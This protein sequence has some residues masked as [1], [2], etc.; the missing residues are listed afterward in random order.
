[1]QR[2]QCEYIVQLTRGEQL[3]GVVVLGNG[4]QVGV[5]LVAD[6]HDTVRCNSVQ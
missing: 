2:E 3:L 4:E 1:M 6:G 5:T